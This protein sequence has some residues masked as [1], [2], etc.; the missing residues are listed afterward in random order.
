MKRRLGLRSSA[1]LSAGACSPGGRS[2]TPGRMALLRRRSWWQQVLA[3]GRH[4]RAKR[5]AAAA[6]LAV[7]ALGDAAR[8]V[9]NHAR[10]F[11]EHAAD[12]RRRPVRHHALQQHRGPRR[13]T[14]KE[15]WRFDGEGYKLGQLLSASGWK[16]RGTAFWR[17]GGKAAHVPEQPASAIFAG[18]A[19]RQACRILWRQRRGVADRRPARE[20][21]TS[22]TSRRARRPTVYKDLVIVGS[23]IP[24]RVQLHDPVGYVQA[25]NARTG[26]RVWTFL[27]DS[28]IG[29]RPGREHVGER[30]VAQQRARQR[31][32]AD[33]ARRSARSAVPA[34]VDA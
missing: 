28:A 10:L 2:L 32:G 11:R 20:S 9:R 18:R 15:L 1:R 17:D 14:G 7:E 4:Q 27:G 29:Q 19:D 26:K 21:A 33:G 23:Q 24:D 16:L 8:R 12:D 25:F 34:D 30:I 6:G 5:A 31:V 13:R 3:A 22:S